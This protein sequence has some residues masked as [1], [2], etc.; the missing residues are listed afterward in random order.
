MESPLELSPQ[1]EQLIVLISTKMTSQLDLTLLCTLPTLDQYLYPI[2]FMDCF[3]FM[4]ISRIPWRPDT[5]T[6]NPAVMNPSLWGVIETPAK[7]LYAQMQVITSVNSISGCPPLL[8]LPPSSRTKEP[9][10]PSSTTTPF[11]PS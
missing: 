10:P 9:S 7:L 4:Q 11:Q 5:A 8:L 3:E 2:H 6:T 1:F